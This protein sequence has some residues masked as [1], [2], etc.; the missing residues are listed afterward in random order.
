MK[1]LQKCNPINM[2]IL[3]LYYNLI[4]N[5][6]SYGNM[7]PYENMVRPEIKLFKYCKMHYS[8]Y[9]VTMKTDFSS[10]TMRA[11]SVSVYILPC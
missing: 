7:E 3:N 9:S 10:C 6:I 11:K 5:T 2:V 4:F 8:F 1:L